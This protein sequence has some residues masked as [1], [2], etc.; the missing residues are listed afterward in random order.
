MYLTFKV[1]IMAS[2]SKKNNTLKLSEKI[3]VIAQIIF[4]DPQSRK[5]RRTR[6]LFWNRSLVWTASKSKLLDFYCFEK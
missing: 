1:H 3:A 2:A 4:L 5:R 6:P